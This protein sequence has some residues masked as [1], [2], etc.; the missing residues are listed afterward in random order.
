MVHAAV[1]SE[2]SGFAAAIC[3]AKIGRLIVDPVFTSQLT[4]EKCKSAASLWSVAS[5]VVSGPGPLGPGT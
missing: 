5:A 4:C 1:T 2:A 3:G